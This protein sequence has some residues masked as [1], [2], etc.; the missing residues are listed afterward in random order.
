M[1]DPS[2]LLPAL[3]RATRPWHD[4][5]EAEVEVLAPALTRDGYR[6]LLELF[7]GFLVDTE[8]RAERTGAWEALRLDAAHRRKLPRLEA[9]L[10]FL[11][12][13]D[14]SL[15]RLPRCADPPRLDERPRA[16]GYLYVFEGATLGGAVIGRHL[17]RAHGFAAGRGAAYFGSY[18]AE[19]GPMWKAFTHAL[20]TFPAGPAERGRIIDGACDTFSKLEQW[21][22]LRRV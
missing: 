10:R 4:R 19:V 5:L 11:G 21:M 16:L 9:D 3:R 14:A 13:H 12:H 15:A 20:E 22:L 1:M 6:R 2:T 8:P 18:G 17:A 7:W